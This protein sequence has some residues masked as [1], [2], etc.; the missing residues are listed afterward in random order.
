VKATLER[1]I[2]ISVADTDVS[3]LVVAPQTARACYVLSHDARVGMQYS[4]LATVAKGLARRNVA[5]LRFQFP[6][7]EEGRRNPDSPK[8]ALATTR[9][10]VSE[11]ARQ[12]PGVPLIAGGKSYGARMTSG[13]QAEAP[14]NNVRGLAFLGFQLRLSG[15][16]SDDHGEHLSS[17]KVP[18]LFLLGTR[19]NLAEPDH[20][21]PLV[22]RLGPL[23]TVKQFDGT[24]DSFHLPAHSG[25]KHI[26]VM[27][28][29][30]DTLAVLINRVI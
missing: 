19:D 5:T 8:R 9:A 29:L 2:T 6:F 30:L 11:A 23:A 20:L 27:T 28:E 21:M 14:L 15:E 26:H 24:D 18:M 10:A 12:V 4:V 7:M 25:S 13:A 3:G 22:E 1:R 16:T 17:I